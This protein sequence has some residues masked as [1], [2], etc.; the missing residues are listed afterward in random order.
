MPSTLHLPPAFGICGYSGAGKTTVI[1]ELIRELRARGLQV[2]VVKHDTHG[3]NIDHEGKDT[4][5]IFRAG[6]DVLI[7]GPG[8]LFL[9]AHDRGALTLHD[10]LRQ[11]APYYDLLLVE[12]HKTT[13]LENKIWLC[14]EG[15]EPPPP[16]A[17]N[18]RRVLL[19]SEDRTR[20]VLEMID[21]WL[22]A[23]WQVAPLH[24]GILIGGQSTRMGRPKHLLADGD[25]T[26]LERTVAVVTPCVAQVVLLGKGELP[27]RLRHLPL[28]PDVPDAQGPL[29]GMLA[30]MRWA[31]AA[32]WLFLPCDVP[33]LSE[34]AIRWLIAQ[35]RPGVWGALPLLPGATR[36][37]PLPGY[38]DWRAARFLERARGPIDLAAE[39]QVAQPPVPPELAGS[40]RN[41]NTPDDLL[42]VA[43]KPGKRIVT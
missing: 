42:A 37:E 9:R 14:G 25:A 26:W 41:V 19:R 27:E 30:A 8:Q 18:I 21:A 36:P 13:P 23:A 22:P 40:W 4:D 16:E 3:L 32:S 29:R 31:P 28:L 11:M 33:L 7:R 10:T 2:G 43:A 15:G 20:I 6:A 35:R 38:Y 39:R 17:N 34:A 24:A 5:R 12:G 1:L